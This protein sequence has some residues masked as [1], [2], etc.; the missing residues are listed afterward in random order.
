MGMKHYFFRLSWAVL[1]SACIA[2]AAVLAAG[3]VTPE[4][5]A[6]N[7][8]HP[9]AVTFIDGGRMLVTERPGRIRVV[10][11]NG[12]VGPALEGVPK[13]DAGGQGGMLDVITDRDFARNRT[14]YFC[15][16]EP[17]K[18]GWGNS[19]ALASARLSDD[20]R[21]LDQV[22]VIFSQKPKYSSSA[23]FGCRIVEHNDGTLFLTMGDRF[24]R[25]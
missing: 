25:M 23:H 11:A 3:K 14:V 9:W 18:S 17:A 13:V 8:E 24:R 19:T 15:F 4:V 1:G 16:S 10:Q 2:P 6:R 5:V 21:R 20:A 12:E 22:K 7:L